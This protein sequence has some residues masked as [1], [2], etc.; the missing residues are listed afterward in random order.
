[1]E[2]GRG[3]PALRENVLAQEQTSSRSQISQRP[4]MRKFSPAESRQNHPA[5]CESHSKVRS[6]MGRTIA[7][8]SAQA[9][10]A[11]RNNSRTDFADFENLLNLPEF[12]PR[13]S[14]PTSLLFAK[15]FSSLRI[16]PYEDSRS[17]V[18][19]REYSHQREPTH[20]HFILPKSFPL[21]E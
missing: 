8:L 4:K 17:R 12:S 18:L 5:M 11:A 16:S 7:Q 14:N 20:A 13:E 2:R 21:C 1:V 19:A 3:P 6:V 15:V 10:I 9:K